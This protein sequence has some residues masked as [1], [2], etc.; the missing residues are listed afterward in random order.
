[1]TAVLT[2]ITKRADP[3]NP[4][5]ARAPPLGDDLTAEMAVKMS[6]IPFPRAKRV[7][8]ATTCNGAVTGVN[9]TESSLV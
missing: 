1:M 2:A 9:V 7:T 8:P 4:D 5:T 3:S 6:E